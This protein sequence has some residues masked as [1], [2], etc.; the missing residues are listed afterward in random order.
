MIGIN[1]GT[2][3]EDSSVL[4]KRLDPMHLALFLLAPFLDSKD[5]SWSVSV[6]LSPGRDKCHEYLRKQYKKI[7]VKSYL[8]SYVYTDLV[9]FHA[10][11][12]KIE[13]LSSTC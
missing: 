12:C 10:G 1:Y 11:L 4:W 9:G 2:I 5:N 13:V 7:S 6:F 3:Q 8:P